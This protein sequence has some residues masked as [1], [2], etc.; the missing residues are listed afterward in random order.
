VARHTPALLEQQILH[1]RAVGQ[2]L[3]DDGDHL[4][5]HERDRSV[6]QLRHDRALQVRNQ[7]VDHAR[8]HRLHEVR[9]EAVQQVRRGSGQSIIHA[10]ADQRPR[11]P[12]QFGRGG[13]WS[14][15]T[16]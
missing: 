4:R 11:P 12:H 2:V 9:H 6:D 8:S 10:V 14:A 13:T 7:T 5:P 1:Q 16:G 3:D 15:Q